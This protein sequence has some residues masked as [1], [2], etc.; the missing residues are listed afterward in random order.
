MRSSNSFA[1]TL[2]N[3]RRRPAPP[4]FIGAAAL[5]LTAFAHGP[6]TTERADSA[7][8]RQFA[9]AKAKAKSDAQKSKAKAKADDEDDAKGGATGQC[10]PGKTFM[11][12]RGRGA[13]SGGS[14]T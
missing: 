13:A 6:A 11:P 10:P 7:E 14:C 2:H 5:M 8:L 1:S 9:Q 3:L 4:I 12:G